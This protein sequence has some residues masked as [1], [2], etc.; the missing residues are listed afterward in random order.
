MPRPVYII[1]AKLIA[2]DR[3]T[4][5]V[6]LSSILENVEITK[7]P[8]T[9]DISDA[10]KKTAEAEN[11][12]KLNAFDTS[13]LS[14]WMYESGDDQ[15]FEHQFAILSGGNETAA[16]KH[17]FKYR[18]D[19]PLQRFRLNLHGMPMPDK[20]GLIEIESRVKKKDGE[21]WIGQRFPITYNIIEAAEP[22]KPQSE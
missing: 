13:V 7:T 11:K 14:V 9:P 5:L 18:P 19:K 8:F 12:A 2:E 10:D 22:I 17:P 21:Q 6:T 3:A 4:N 20:S 16:E 1:C 15:E